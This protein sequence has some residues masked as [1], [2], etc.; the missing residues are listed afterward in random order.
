MDRARRRADQEELSK[1]VESGICAVAVR[2]VDGTR[3][4]GASAPHRRAVEMD[5]DAERGKGGDRVR[6]SADI[7]KEV[8]TEKKTDTDRETG[9]G[10]TGTTRMG[11]RIGRIR[12]RGRGSG[13]DHLTAEVDVIG[14]EIAE[15]TRTETA[16]GSVRDDIAAAAAA[17]AEA[18]AATAMAAAMNPNRATRAAEAARCPPR[19]LVL[20]DLL[21]PLPPTDKLNKPVKQAHG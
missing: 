20:L 10:E 3:T 6:G 15:T 8:T 18:E 13:S 17:A 12:L 19:H 7:G 21:A 5:V 16:A 1:G 2:A 4:A 9:T 14:V 11:G